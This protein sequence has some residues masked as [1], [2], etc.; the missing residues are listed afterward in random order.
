MLNAPWM[1]VAR[2]LEGTAEISGAANN[3]KVLEMYRLSH[4]ENI[5]ADSVPW[6]AAFVGACLRLSGFDNSRSLLASSYRTF[7]RPLSFPVEG[8]IITLKP[9]S[10]GASGHVGFYVT[11]DANTVTLLGGNQSDRVK[12]S[13]FKK[14]DIVAVRLPRDAAP[15]PRNSL[16]PTIL[17]LDPESAPDHLRTGELERPSMP[18]NLAGKPIFGGPLGDFDAAVEVVLKEEG[19]FSNHPADTGGATRFGITI[20]TLKAFR[21]GRP[22]TVEDV[23][24]LSME[25]ALTIYRHLYWDTIMGDSLPMPLALMT[26]NAGVLFGFDDGAR[27]LQRALNA[28]NLGVDVDGD[29]G[30]QTCNASLA[31]DIPRAVR[32]FAALQRARHNAHPKKDIFRGWF[33]RLDRIEARALQLWND[34]AA[35]QPVASSPVP[36]AIVVPA[37]QPSVTMTVSNPRP[38]VQ[39]V[40]PPSFPMPQPEAPPSSHGAP[41]GGAMASESELLAKLSEIIVLLQRSNQGIQ[42]TAPVAPLEDRLRAMLSVLREA[43][44]K[45]TPIAS[46]GKEP[47]TPINA[48]LGETVGRALNG[49]KTAIGIVGA[50]ATSVLGSAPS[51]TV[52]D[53]AAK[54]VPILAGGPATPIFMALGAWGA[55][56]RIE[57]IVM[58]RRRL[59]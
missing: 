36:Q 9:Q 8:A 52:I 11:E 27:F 53:V 5:A 7:G 3:P 59:A 19:G 40:F 48:A 33:A 20:G 23:R 54:A 50:T 55:L 10:A 21:K 28:Q 17:S 29:V 43:T 51:G 30:P 1:A 16:L 44:S 46:D 58:A 15:L 25:E 57:K 31:C 42:P 22:T 26:F 34:F 41:F 49:W 37:P 4:A 18:A 45:P 6:C 13:R 2:E 24:N 12:E 47:L 39:P 38:T 32:D 14:S 35:T 56:G